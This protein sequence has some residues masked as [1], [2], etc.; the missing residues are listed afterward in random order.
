MER[1][2]RNIRIYM[3]NGR[4]R[5]KLIVVFSLIVVLIVI[6][7]SYLSYRQSSLMNEDNFIVS[8]QK[9]MKLVNQNLDN[10]ISKIDEFSLYSSE[11]C[12]FHGRHYFK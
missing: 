5:S 2:F 8:N 12:C 4:L 1:I 11:R 7:L 3:F 6:L 10:Y 9:I